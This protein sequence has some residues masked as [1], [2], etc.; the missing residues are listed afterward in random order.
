MRPRRPIPL[1]WIVLG[2]TLLVLGRG[3]CP[4]APAD[5]VG[6]PLP[7]FRALA[8]ADRAGLD[9]WLETVRAQ[10]DRPLS[11]HAHPGPAGPR[12]AA[13]A[14]RDPERPRWEPRHDA[15]IDGFQRTFEDQT[16]RERWPLALAGVATGDSAAFVSVWGGG[17]DGV[18]HHVL[19]AAG[20]EAKLAEWSPRG[21]G[22]VTLAA[23]NWR[24]QRRYA[25]V[26]DRSAGGA[27]TVE[28]ELDRAAL[29]AALP[30]WRSQGRQPVA[31]AVAPALDDPD[32]PRFSV[33]LAPA[34]G[35]A[36]WDLTLDRTAEQVA[37]ALDADAPPGRQP[38]ALAGYRQG[39]SERFA[40]LWG[41]EPVVSPL[42]MTGAAVPD[43]AGF[44]A[45][46]Q[47]YMGRRGIRAGT[48]AVMR[49]GQVVLQRGYGWRDRDG[50]EP[51]PPDA[52]LRLASVSK[53]FTAAAVRTLIARGQLSLE[54]RVAPRLDLKPLAGKRLDPRW[55]A[56]TVAHLLEHRGGWDRAQSGDP[57]FRPIPIAR[58]F[59]Q[60]GPVT[61]RMIVDYMAG[62]PLQFDPGAKSVYSNFG[63]C[64][65]GR[66]IERVTGQA[67]EPALRELVLE[68]L[69][70]RS[71]RV[72][73]SRPADR[74]PHEP[75]YSDPGRV[76]SPWQADREPEQAELVPLPDGGFVI[77]AMDAHGGLIGSAADV[78]RFF[79][80]YSNQGEPIAGRTVSGTFF[81]SLPGTLS[82]ARRRPDGTVIVA[83]FNQRGGPP[84]SED[85]A[86]LR[87][88]ER[89][90][91][92]AFPPPSPSP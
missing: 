10:G 92:V 22:P 29:E 14:R 34:A 11:L 78:A 87:L 48:L 25:A 66:L 18:C 17:G 15:D 8:G 39:S 57:M 52:P 38:R 7:R 56:I 60:P 1:A 86:I 70:L 77:E 30:R 71:V 65:L 23:Y 68:P 74:D 31:L 3:R 58:A 24:G 21:V 12:F 72:G 55:Q 61:A 27:R 88:L 6:P 32:S 46:M 42:P 91:D 49:G 80:A 40:L 79:D 47:A 20:L 19:D 45:A 36:G 37:A 16:R 43:L 84:G 51:L 67:F 13:L 82:L 44:D 5:E 54:T 64:A 90:A 9:T 2:L 28:R 63:Y 81:G 53:P 26:W 33:V 50:T 85:G 35:G 4:A 83:L 73:R 62:E 75:F 59:G 41:P 76:P 89:A 69:G